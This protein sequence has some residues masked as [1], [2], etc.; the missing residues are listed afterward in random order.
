MKLLSLVISEAMPSPLILFAQW[1]TPL[2]LKYEILRHFYKNEW[3]W[4][5][6]NIMLIK[7]FCRLFPRIMC[8]RLL[9]FVPL[10]EN[11]S[12]IY[13]NLRIWILILLSLFTDPQVSTFLYQVTRPWIWRAQ[14]RAGLWSCCNLGSLFG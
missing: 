6:I 9:S 10:N 2:M 11:G 7:E 12:I 14:R 13:L 8:K 3:Q 1:P 5:K 4:F